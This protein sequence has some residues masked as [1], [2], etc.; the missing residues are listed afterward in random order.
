MAFAKGAFLKTEPALPTR[1]FH[2]DRDNRRFV[3]PSTL[4]GQRSIS[5]H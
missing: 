3:G 1:C 5:R 2:Y 4:F